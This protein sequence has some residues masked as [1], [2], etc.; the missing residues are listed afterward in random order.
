MT[1]QIE[2]A[3]SALLADPR[4]RQLAELPPEAEWFANLDN[5]HTRRAYES[6][7]KAF[8][9]FLGVARMEDIREVRRGHVIAWRDSLVAAGHSPATIRRKLAALSSLYEY[10]CDNNAVQGNPVDGVRRP[11]EGVNEGKTP[12]ISDAQARALLKAPN[13]ET[14]KGVRDA[15]LLSVLLYSGIRVSELC[16]LRVKDIEERRG[17]KFFHV[18]G[19]GTKIRY[20]LIHPIVQGRLHDYLGQVEHAE[21]L[22][23]PLFRPI[24]NNRTGETAR[25][26]DR[27]HVFRMIRQYGLSVGLS[28]RQLSPHVL[29]TTLITNALEH[30]ADIAKVQELAGHASIAT[31]R[32]YDRRENRPED[33]PVNL[34]AY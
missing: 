33:S 16:Q 13:P 3:Q 25:A 28:A 7:V 24:R 9:G 31:T 21:D 26:L 12:A 6:D 32:L 10:L 11:S 22:A 20:V 19:K 18:R 5:A 4:L 2:N 14:P 29:R 27:S 23:G 30:Q 34:V 15:A 17:A 8:F 1:N